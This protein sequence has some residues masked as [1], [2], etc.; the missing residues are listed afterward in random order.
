MSFEHIVVGTRKGVEGR[1]FDWAVREG[2][3]VTVVPVQRD[4]AKAAVPL[5]NQRMT[6]IFDPACL[7]A[8]GGEREADEMIYAAK[9]AH[10]PVWL[11]VGRVAGWMRVP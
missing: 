3:A 7:L 8:F 1:A 11:W 6:K 2:V 9:L 4:D 10:L 5:R